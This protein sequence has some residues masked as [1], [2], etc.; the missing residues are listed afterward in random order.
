LQVHYRLNT[1]HLN[2]ELLDRVHGLT[3]AHPGRCP[4]YL[5]FRKPTGEIAFVEAHERFQ[6]SPSQALQEAVDEL[7]GEETYYAKID[8]ALP[9]RQQRRWERRADDSEAA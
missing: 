1:A 8:T 3:A 9:E 5:C 4:L 7:L 6:V 2:P